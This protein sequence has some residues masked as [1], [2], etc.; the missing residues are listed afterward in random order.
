MGHPKHLDSLSH[1]NS[2]LNALPQN[3]SPSGTVS[4]ALQLNISQNTELEYS[5]TRNWKQASSPPSQIVDEICMGQQNNCT[6]CIVFYRKE[7]GT[8]FQ[9]T[10]DDEG[11]QN[12][13]NET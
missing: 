10:K 8:I 9:K 3:P 7:E 5:R 11:N 13:R 1:Q 6:L 2:S 4:K 12:S